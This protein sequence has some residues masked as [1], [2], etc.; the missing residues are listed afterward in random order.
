MIVMICHNSICNHEEEYSEDIKY[1]P[2]CG[3]EL[4]KVILEKGDENTYE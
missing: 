3:D 4:V 1:C 2:I